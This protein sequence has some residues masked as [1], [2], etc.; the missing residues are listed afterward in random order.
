MQYEKKNAKPISFNNI[1]FF[2]RNYMKQ[3]PPK[4]YLNFKGFRPENESA[5]RLGKMH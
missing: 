4:I 5:N 2:L 1:F 3:F